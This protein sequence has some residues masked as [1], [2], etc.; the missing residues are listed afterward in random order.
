MYTATVAN[1]LLSVQRQMFRLVYLPEIIEQ[2]TTLPSV[3]VD[4]DGKLELDPLCY[5]QP[6]QLCE[7]R[8]DVVVPRG[9]I[10]LPSSGIY[11]GMHSLDEMDKNAVRRRISIVQRLQNSK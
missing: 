4:Q 9:G 7:E 11:H 1:S 8:R 3:S 2:G 10:H 6:T 5:I